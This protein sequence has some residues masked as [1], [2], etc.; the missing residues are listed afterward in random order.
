MGIL[1]EQSVA[2]GWIWQIAFF[3][4][5]DLIKDALIM[6]QA[7]ISAM[8]GDDERDF[9]HACINHFQQSDALDLM[10]TALKETAAAVGGSTE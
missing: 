2:E 9:R 5:A 4:L 8:Q 6:P 1:N 3:D 7:F 10:I